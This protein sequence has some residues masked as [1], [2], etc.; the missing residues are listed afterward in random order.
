[1]SNKK[2]GSLDFR[3]VKNTQFD[4]AQT[5]KLEFSELQSSKRVYLTNAILKDAYTH[6]I[7][8][9]NVDNLPT[10]VEYYQA[11]KPVIDRINFGPDVSQSLAGTYIILQEYITK[12][13]TAFYYVVDGNGTAPGVADEEIAVNISENDPAPVVALSTKQVM[14]GIEEFIVKQKN[15]L[16]GYI[17]VEYLQFGETEAIDTGTSGFIVTRVQEGESYKVGE[18]ELSYDVDN[19][20]IYNGNTLRGLLY[21]PYTASFDVE[22]DNIDVT[23]VSDAPSSFQVSNIEV[24]T[25][26]TETEITI[27]DNVKKYRIKAREPDTIIRVTNVSGGDY[28]TIPYGNVYEENDIKTNGVSLFIETNKNNKIIELITWS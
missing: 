28:F 16:S 17:D 13:T 7:Q 20:P 1:M 26:N 4:A 10:K 18:V 12:K 19:N 24:T 2:N 9:L 3:N 27:A 21:N 5:S 14:D 15:F 8:T 23:V 25:A 22:R 11:T 6:F